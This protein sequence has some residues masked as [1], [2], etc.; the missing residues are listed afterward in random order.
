MKRL[1]PILAFLLILSYA[2]GLSIS[3]PAEI[4]ANTNWSF[5]VG[6]DAQG[7]YTK[8]SVYIND[9]EV[10]TVFPAGVISDARYVGSAA[11]FTGSSGTTLYVSALGLSEGSFTIKAKAFNGDAVN[12]EQSATVNVFKPFGEAAKQE[13]KNEIRSEV[14]EFENTLGNVQGYQEA[15]KTDI[16]NLQDSVTSLQELS[17]KIDALSEKVDGV[18]SSVSSLE[19]K[20][21]AVEEDVSPLVTGYKEK[22]AAEKNGPLTGF[23]SLASNIPVVPIL[24]AIVVIAVIAGAFMVVSKRGSSLYF[25]KDKRINELDAFTI[26]GSREEEE[27]AKELSDGKWAHKK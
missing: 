6:L 2:S 20:V 18:G 24:L 10:A 26:K 27:M 7:S 4:P 15:M 1:F 5:S 14:S 25:G 16:K 11:V 8:T 22:L 9:A 12:S 23:A 17:S 3:A 21:N 13:L 19:G